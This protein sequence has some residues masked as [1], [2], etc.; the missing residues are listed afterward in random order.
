VLNVWQ[1][2]GSMMDPAAADVYEPLYPRV[3]GRWVAPGEDYSA[4]N[5]GHPAQELLDQLP[6]LQLVDE[7]KVQVCLPQPPSK[8]PARVEPYVTVLQVVAVRAA[9]LLFV[10]TKPFLEEE[11]WEQV[12]AW[13]QSGGLD[14]IHAVASCTSTAST[15]SHVAEYHVQHSALLGHPKYNE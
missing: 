7:G 14:S 6:H 1:L 12:G 5:K 9:D 10:G 3:D 15:C 2:Q 4:A 11:W 8:A 13:H